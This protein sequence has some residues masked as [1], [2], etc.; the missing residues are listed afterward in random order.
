MAQDTEHTDNAC[1]PGENLLGCGRVARRLL[2]VGLLFSM[3]LHLAV[4][5]G[6][7]WLAAAFPH[8]ELP[9]G[10]Y[11]VEIVRPE[12][13]A[14]TPPAPPQE[15]TPVAAPEPDKGQLAGREAQAAAAAP[16]QPA[17][18]PA[19]AAP[20]PAGEPASLDM[21][22]PVRVA[23]E[24]AAARFT[25]EA[26]AEPS[27]PAEPG[28]LDIAPQEARTA[29][30]AAPQPAADTGP[31]IG[32]VQKTGETDVGG[33]RGF[34]G[35]ADTFGLDRLARDEFK[36]REF[37]GFYKVQ[38]E[39]DHYLVVVDALATRGRL[40]LLDRASGFLRSLKPHN[41]M[42]Y[43]YGPPGGGDEP[44]EGVVYLMPRKSRY[45]NDNINLPHQ[46]VWMRDEPPALVAEMVRIREAELTVRSRG[47]ELRA[48]LAMPR[49]GGPYPGVV[50]LPGG[51]EP[52]AVRE[53]FARSLAVR[54][55]AAL[56]F[57]YPGCQAAG[58]ESSRVTLDDLAADTAAALAELRRADGVDAARCGLWGRDKGVW[59]AWRAATKAQPGQGP[60]FLVGAASAEQGGEAQPLALPEADAAAAQAPQL[61]LLSAPDPARTWRQGYRFL[62]GLAHSGRPVEVTLYPE[63]PPAPGD[64][65]A[66]LSRQLMPWYADLGARWVTQRK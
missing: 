21:V 34:S 55:I 27:A 64:E 38:G 51:C 12:P 43:S 14:E 10:I 24:A 63:E 16:A 18:A 20:A 53:G 48:M 31:V 56:V 66:S 17:A 45:A 3:A 52:A 57:D 23:S 36:L 2:P 50:W 6:G 60:A 58:G 19:A 22:A 42:V 61:W 40:L 54:G 7:L 62:D 41:P 1:I 44:V 15:P 32:V 28:A 25:G 65:A 37:A 46:V 13:P 30:P 26:V 47:R 59:V 39:T 11:E 8:T 29:A 35:Q 33:M 4:V 5:A 9:P 49:H